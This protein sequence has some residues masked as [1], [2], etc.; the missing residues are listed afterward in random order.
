[1]FNLLF[2]KGKNMTRLKK[3]YQDMEVHLNLSKKL[4]LKLGFYFF[5][6][7]CF[8]FRVKAVTCYTLS[9]LDSWDVLFVNALVKCLCII[10]TSYYS[11][12]RLITICKPLTHHRE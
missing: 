12:L 11:L 8:S 10:N 7:N 9:D 1:M 6:L 2:E 3:T 5:K 4:K